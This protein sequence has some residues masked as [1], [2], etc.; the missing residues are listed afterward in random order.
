MM[1]KFAK[2][3]L[4]HFEAHPLRHTILTFV[5]VIVA[6]IAINYAGIKAAESLIRKN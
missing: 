4:D 1:E 2:A 5:G 6:Y 3:N